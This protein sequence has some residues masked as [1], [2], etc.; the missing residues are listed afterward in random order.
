MKNFQE[1]KTES[2]KQNISRVATQRTAG[3]FTQ[4][5]AGLTLVELLVVI[6]IL[7]T[8]VGGVLPLLSPN[9]EARKIESASRGLKTY[10]QRAQTRAARTGRP[11]GIAFRESSLDSGI[12]LEVFQVENPRPF[13]GFSSNSTAK[14][15]DPDTTDDTYKY[16]IQF[17][18]GFGTDFQNEQGPVIP[19]R[20]VRLG[21]IIKIGNSRFKLER[22][23]NRIETTPEGSFFEPTNRF[24]SAALVSGPAP[25][26]VPVNLKDF[27]VGNSGE[28]SYRSYPRNYGIARQPVPTSEAPFVL[29]KGVAIDMHA[30]GTE[31]GAFP[32]LLAANYGDNLKQLSL[33]FSPSGGIDSIYY[34]GQRVGEDEYQNVSAFGDRMQRITDASRFVLLLTQIE[35]GGTPII[36]Y[37]DNQQIADTWNLD[38]NDSDERLSEVREEVSWLNLDS[39]WMVVD[40]RNGKTSLV[41][42]PAVDPRA[43]RFAKARRSN[44]QFAFQQIMDARRGGDNI[45][46]AGAKST[47]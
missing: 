5:T 30:S 18:T 31:G 46:A 47:Q 26:T 19:P 10:F 15:W 11:V 7:V 3:F 40:G 22:G 16:I 8:L 25:P 14:F 38:D 33:M 24:W 44:T 23:K 21:D 41:D 13:T 27:K 6:V 45:A 2:G 36:N 39:R 37:N 42:N 43:D 29:P 32:T 34:N 35:L 9:N 4:H 28:K 1:R 20:M 12:A 17:G